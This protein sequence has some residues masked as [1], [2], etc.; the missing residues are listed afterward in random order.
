[1]KTLKYFV[2][3]AIII[4]SLFAGYRLNCPELSGNVVGFVYSVFIVPL[5][6]IIIL[7]S[8]FRDVRD[9][10]V[11]A[12]LRITPMYVFEPVWITLVIYMGYRK[13]GLAMISETLMFFYLCIVTYQAK[14]EM[15]E[16]EDKDDTVNS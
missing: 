10:L 15:P 14:K 5:Y 3:N 2:W 1:M 16:S 11:K 9:G 6:A 7:F 4:G 12:N 8:G 13:I